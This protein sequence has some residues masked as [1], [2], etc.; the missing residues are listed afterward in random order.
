ME[1]INQESSAKVPQLGYKDLRA[2]YQ[3]H[4][5]D[6]IIQRAATLRSMQAMRATLEQRLLCTDGE[7]LV[8]DAA[9]YNL[10]LKLAAQESK[11]RVLLETSLKAKAAQ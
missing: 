8:P 6:P 9:N 11:E 2:H 4:V 7:E 3:L 1:V 5:C 10:F